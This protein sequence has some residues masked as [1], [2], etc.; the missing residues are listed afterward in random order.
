M[1]NVS[2]G[3]CWDAALKRLASVRS[4]AVVG[5]VLAG[6]LLVSTNALAD[7]HSFE[8]KEYSDE[9]AVPAGQAEETLETQERGA[10]IVGEL[11]QRL[12]GRYAGVWF[13]NER[14]EFVVPLVAEAGRDAVD[15]ELAAANLKSASRI[16]PAQSTWA[17]LEAAQERIDKSLGG[18]LR[19]GIVQTSLDP[20]TNAV[21]IRMADRGS[22]S[23]QAEIRRLTAGES[24]KVELEAK[25]SSLLHVT[26]SACHGLP[27]Y[28]DAPM[29]GGVDIQAAGSSCCGPAC[30]AG[31]K[32]IGDTNGNRFVLTAGH[33]TVRSGITEWNSFTTDTQGHYL[34][35]VAAAS[36][37][38]HDYAAIKAN[39]T[40]WDKSPWPSTIVNW[41]VNQ[42][43]PITAE[44]YSYLGEAVCH[45][46]AQSQKSCGVVSGLHFTSTDELGETLKNL[47]EFRIIC[48]VG[49]DSGGPVFAGNTALGLYSSSVAVGSEEESCQHIGYY[50]EITEDTDA[51]AVHVA[52]RIPPPPTPS[53]HQ[54]NL[55]GGT[56][57]EPA[58]SS[59]GPGRL[60]VFERATD[61]VLYHRAFSATQW[62]G[63]E[64]LGGNLA[65]G[66]SAASWEPGRI[67]VVAR[68]TGTNNINHQWFQSGWGGPDV[69]GTTIDV[70]GISSWGTNRLDLFERAADNNLYHRCWCGAQGWLGWEKIGEGLASG[71]DA[72]SWGPGRIDVVAEKTNHSVG[73]WYWNGSSW[74]S[75]NLNGYVTAKPTIS[76]QGENK[77]DVFARGIDNGLYHL[78]WTGSGWGNWEQMGSNL[79]TGPDAVSWGNNRIDVVAGIA[80]GTINHWWYGN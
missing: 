57:V 45:V 46:G 48:S 41:G 56:T 27:S 38:I 13:D 78:F 20:R 58:I 18:L 39:G 61:N 76:S 50:T 68:A 52:P 11:Q 10:A 64:S 73:H 25:G 23:T 67:D 6:C 12:G 47:T 65:S 69:L 74:A 60:D 32:G 55:G 14:G 31:F 63:W 35:V 19:E 7:V 72:V 34:G 59:W 49:G 62:L 37:P 22:A 29:R 51:L 40:Y 44:S 79:T 53:W 9:F 30:T 5:L 17:E 24:V 43:Y 33:C 80:G 28:C 75:D 71:P 70:P 2:P 54:D 15:G 1:G 42:E 36:F 26:P 8:V 77:L 4:L 16:A 66:P 3:R 21:V